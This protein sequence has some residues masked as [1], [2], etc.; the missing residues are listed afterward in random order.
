MA[1]RNAKVPGWEA[2]PAFGNDVSVYRP[3]EDVGKRL[4]RRAYWLWLQQVFGEGSRLPWHIFRTYPGGVQGFARAGHSAWR[5]LSYLTLKHLNALQVYRPE[6]AVLKLNY[7]FRMGWDVLTP[8]SEKYPAALRNISDPPAVLYVQG[9]LGYLEQWPWVAVVG[10]RKAGEE[11]LSAAERLAYELS[12]SGAVVV[13]GIA[14]GIDSAALEGASRAGVPAISVLPVDLTAFQQGN[15]TPG[16]WEREKGCVLVTEYFSQPRPLQ[17]TF[18]QRNRL[19]TGMSHSLVLV[20]AGEKGGSMIYARH[21][22]KQE[23]RIFVYPGSQDDPA[24]AGNR[25]LIAQGAEILKTGGELFRVWP[26]LS[27][28]PELLLE[29]QRSIISPPKPPEKGRRLGRLTRD[30]KRW[31]IAQSR[32]FLHRTSAKDNGAPLRESVMRLWEAVPEM[33]LLATDP[34]RDV[35]DGEPLLR[36]G[37]MEE[38]D[39]PPGLEASPQE[40]PPEPSPPEQPKEAERPGPNIEAQV[41]DSLKGKSLAVEEISDLTGI[42]TGALLRLLLKLEI[43]GRVSRSPGGQYCVNEIS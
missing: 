32:G 8:E 7:A 15:L 40:T 20:Q 14:K 43:T 42:E 41:L 6:Q 31:R 39:P 19:I 4:D 27:G 25:K 28:L 33:S 30:P 16:L 5:N 13:S 36:P 12:L 3:R 38:E 21:A 26:E 23:R 10:A 17:G 9:N 2:W 37:D 18:Q 24:F 1:N 35:L 22:A 29:Q 34:I 11:G